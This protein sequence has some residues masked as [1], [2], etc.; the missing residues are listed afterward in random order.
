MDVHS[1]DREGLASAG[2]INRH[3]RR[4]RLRQLAAE[5]GAEANTIVCEWLESGP[6]GGAHLPIPPFEP[7][8]ILGHAVKHLCDV[9]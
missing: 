8:Q 2:E 4:A 1:R 7:R 9:R 6:A 5:H 3:R